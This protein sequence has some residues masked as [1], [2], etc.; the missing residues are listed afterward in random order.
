M[1]ATP[2][3]APEH[4]LEPAERVAAAE[5]IIASAEGPDR[6]EEVYQAF[7]NE[8]AQALQPFALTL[9]PGERVK[10]WT[11]IA[12]LADAHLTEELRLRLPTE[13]RVRISLAQYRDHALLEAAIAQPAPGFLL[14]G[15]RLFAR[16]PGFRE[17]PHGLADEWFEAATERVTVRLARGVRPRY[18]V[19]TGVKRAD[20]HLE[21]SFFVP[22]EGCGAESVRVG[23][24]RLEKGEAPRKRTCVDAAEHPGLDVE[25][26][27]AVRAEGALAVVTA[28]VPTAELIGH[29]AGRW[30]LRAHL[31]LRGFTYDLPLKAPRGYFQR[32][33]MPVG[34]A[35]EWG[36]KRSLTVRVDERATWRGLSRLRMLDFR[37]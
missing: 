20:Y 35:V 32:H 22:V 28:R 9:D 11:A 18:L 10:C 30:S 26:E 7:T 2:A 3:A 33:G 27:V 34:L 24:D 29:G 31:T 17:E 16:Y 23:A 14:E 36:A 5:R 21:Y 13:K 37:K 25:A 6:D 4:V 1:N 19:W 8:V 15:G 12:E